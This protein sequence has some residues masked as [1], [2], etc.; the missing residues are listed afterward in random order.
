MGKRR[1]ISIDFGR[2]ASELLG[3]VPRRLPAMR[4]AELNLNPAVSL[5][6]LLD[7]VAH[8]NHGGSSGL[9]RA[10]RRVEWTAVQI[11]LEGLR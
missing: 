11:A 1:A 8:D 7:F 4:S 6:P 3:M 10:P 9:S 2:N 5:G